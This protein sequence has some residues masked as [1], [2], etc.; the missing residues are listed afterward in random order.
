MS[1]KPKKEPPPPIEIRR[2][3]PGFV[4]PKTE[5][6]LPFKVSSKEEFLNLDWVKVFQEASIKPFNG[7]RYSEEVKCLFATY[8]KGRYYEQW[9]ACIPM[10]DE[11]E[12]R[13]I[14]WFGKFE[15]KA[16]KKEET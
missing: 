11:A 15:D 7:F 10:D 1:K 16:T 3:F 13:L 6:R 12:R 14:E 4:T 5:D 8:D 2:Y 9:G